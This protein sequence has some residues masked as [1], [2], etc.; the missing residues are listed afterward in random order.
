MQKNNLYVWAKVFWY[1][2]PIVLV[3]TIL[4]T[5]AVSCTNKQIVIHYIDTLSVP[6]N[7]SYVRSYFAPVDQTIRN[8]YYYETED[9]LA[10][11]NYCKESILPSN[12]FVHKNYVSN[13][14]VEND[15][16][17][18]IQFPSDSFFIRLTNRGEIIDTVKLRMGSEKEEPYVMSTFLEQYY[19]PITKDSGTLYCDFFLPSESDFHCNYNSRKSKFSKPVLAKFIV[20]KKQIYQTAEGIGRYPIA[21]LQKDSVRYQYYGYSTM[22]KDTDIVTVYAFVDSLFVTHRDGSQESHFFRSK[23]QK[24]TNEILNV[25]VYDYIGIE[26]NLFSQTYYERV[27]YDPYRN[28]YY[29]TVSKPKCYENNDGTR[30]SLSEKPWSLVILNKEYKLLTEIDMP[31]QFSKD[32]LM[33]MPEGLAIMDKSLTKNNNLIFVICNFY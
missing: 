29:V 28:L 16:S 30:N 33:V 10:V 21:H 31:N 11:F 22:N 27:L 3:L 5:H 2:C 9:G 7:V 23:Y 20:G 14:I 13:Y 15:S 26:K 25:S 24:H 1:L 6:H 18:L 4:F 12:Q 19:I 17:I 32:R 8:T